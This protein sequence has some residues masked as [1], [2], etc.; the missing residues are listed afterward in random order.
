VQFG[1]PALYLLHGSDEDA[2][3]S[4]GHVPVPF[5]LLQLFQLLQV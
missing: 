1:F 3:T 4:Q 2:G 5:Q